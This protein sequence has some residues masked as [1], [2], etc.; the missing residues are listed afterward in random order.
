[1]NLRIL[2]ETCYFAI[3]ASLLHFTASWWK[4]IQHVKK[5]EEKVILHLIFHSF[6]SAFWKE[7]VHSSDITKLVRTLCPRS[8]QRNRRGRISKVWRMH[9]VCKFC[10]ERKATINFIIIKDLKMVLMMT[11]MDEIR[12]S[13]SRFQFFLVIFNFTLNLR[14]PP[15]TKN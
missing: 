15:S 5:K 2:W 3:I 14:A 11:T 1:M 7:Q 9:S 12:E 10:K 6:L 4:F 13:Q 8:R